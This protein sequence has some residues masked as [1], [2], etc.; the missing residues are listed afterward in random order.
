MN[1]VFFFIDFLLNLVIP[2]MP[3]F[4]L[5]YLRLPRNCWDTEPIIVNSIKIST[6]ILLSFDII[7]FSFRPFVIS[8]VLLINRIINYDIP[9]NDLQLVMGFKLIK[10]WMTLSFAHMFRE[11]ILCRTTN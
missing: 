3:A 1:H 11:A 7:S 10:R 6:I 4:H 5:W 2:R 8:M 9:L